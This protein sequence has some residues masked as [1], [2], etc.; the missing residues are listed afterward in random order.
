MILSIVMFVPVEH[1]RS[2]DN[3]VC[4][5]KQSNGQKINLSKICNKS[6]RKPASKPD[7]PVSRPVQHD[8]TT[9]VSASRTQIN[10]D[11]SISEGMATDSGGPPTATITPTAN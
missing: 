8:R 11:G 10:A 7:L 1:A 5:I 3:S 9:A 6:A 4:Y 2:Q